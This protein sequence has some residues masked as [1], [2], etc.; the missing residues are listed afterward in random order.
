MKGKGTQNQVGLKTNNPTVA[1]VD[2][3][4]RSHMVLR[5]TFD[6]ELLSIRM[7]LCEINGFLGLDQLD[8]GNF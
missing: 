1:I 8:W 7:I 5:F 3:K 6:S 2:T 4:K